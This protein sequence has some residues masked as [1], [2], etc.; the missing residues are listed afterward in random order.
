MLVRIAKREDPG[1]T[2]SALFYK[3]ILAGEHF[4]RTSTIS[5]DIN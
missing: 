5:R 2:G 1:Q 3:H 4:N